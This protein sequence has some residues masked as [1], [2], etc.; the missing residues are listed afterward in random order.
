[1][2]SVVFE[3]PVVNAEIDISNTVLK[4][5]RLILRP[6]RKEDLDDFFEYASVDGVGQ[7]AGWLPHQSKDDTQM[8]LDSFI[9]KKRTFALEYQGK[10][11]GSLGIEEYD[12]DKFPELK[13]KKCREIG[14]VLSKN[15]WGRGL[16]PEA[17]KETIRYLFEEVRLDVIL[18]GHFLSN[19]QSQRVQEK[20]GF[21]HYA[22]GTYET[23]FG[24]V[25]EDET[26]IMTRED[27]KAIKKMT[28]EL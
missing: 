18:C 22:Y 4:T 21:R 6:W 27:W 1:M 17:V 23:R 7:M 5:E 16:M 24:T 8:I 28:E 3:V 25:E 12:E 11:V 14:Y 15:Y 10:V 2:N 20:C 19:Q 26:N 9:G 13:D